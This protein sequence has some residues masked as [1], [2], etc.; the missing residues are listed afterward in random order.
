M[1]GLGRRTVMFQLP[2][3][4]VILN[5]DLMHACLAARADMALGVAATAAAQEITRGTMQGLG[6]GTVPEASRESSGAE[7]KKEGRGE[8]GSRRRRNR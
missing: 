5:S 3:N 6:A 4:L 2:C 1:H 8:K 7:G